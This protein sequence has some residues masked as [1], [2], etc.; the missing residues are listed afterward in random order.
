MAGSLSRS[1]AGPPPECG[2]DGGMDT[3]HAKKNPVRQG[4]LDDVVGY[5]VARARVTTQA[6]FLRHVGQP[7]ELR[8]VEYSLLMLLDA[9]IRLTPK[10]LAQALALSAPNLT[11]LLDRMQERGLIERIRSETDRRSQHV[12]LSSAG[13]ALTDQAL[14]RTPAM[15]ADLDGALSRAERAMLIELLD[16]VARH[17]VGA[18]D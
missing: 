13:R 4:V 10:Q 15:E 9:S 1:P 5:H 14:A 12:L 17:Q 6:M 18:A 7:L 16:K 3:S 2:Q 8:P 11:I